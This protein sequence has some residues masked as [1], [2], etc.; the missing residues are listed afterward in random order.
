MWKYLPAKDA[1]KV[2]GVVSFEKKM[3]HKGPRARA[4]IDSSGIHILFNVVGLLVIPNCIQ[5]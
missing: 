4:L 1:E 5:L 3:C 2:V